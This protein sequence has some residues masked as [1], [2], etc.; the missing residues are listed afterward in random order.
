MVKVVLFLLGVLLSGC[1]WESPNF[2]ELDYLP[3]DDTEFPYAGLPRLVIETKDFKEIR[4]RE[5]EHEAF[6]QIY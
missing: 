2:Q 3:L 5:T 6:F 1:L 4:N